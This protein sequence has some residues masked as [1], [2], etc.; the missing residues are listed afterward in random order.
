MF[1]AHLPKVTRYEE[2]QVN[3]NVKKEEWGEE[4]D[5]MFYS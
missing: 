4:K 1:L 2:W 5:N 3:F